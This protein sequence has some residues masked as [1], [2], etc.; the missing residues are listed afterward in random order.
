MAWW[1][2]GQSGLLDSAGG[3]N[4]ELSKNNFISL[5]HGLTNK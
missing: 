5:I 2:K 3:G 4:K 1:W